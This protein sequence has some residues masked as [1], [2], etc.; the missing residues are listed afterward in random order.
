RC[1]TRSARSA[2]KRLA[3]PTPAW[4]S[5][6]A[7]GSEEGLRTAGTATAGHG[8]RDP[9]SLRPVAYH[10]VGLVAQRP[11]LEAEQ[12]G[13]RQGLRRRRHRLEPV[14]RADGEGLE[15]HL[16]GGARALADHLQH[17]EL[18]D[19]VEVDELARPAPVVLEDTAVRG[20]HQARFD[21]RDLVL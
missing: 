21:A 19:A 8:A 12:L 9:R 18:A 1:R 14:V 4:R 20:A 6:G 3:A 10:P 5:E 13:V 17:R 2:R 11:A 7:G 15:R 16:V